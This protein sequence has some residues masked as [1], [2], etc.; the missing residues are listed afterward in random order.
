[1]KRLILVLLLGFMF[2]FT[3]SQN[4]VSADEDVGNIEY[5][6]KTDSQISADI[7]VVIADP[8]GIVNTDTYI[9]VQKNIL[10][11]EVAENRVIYYND[12]YTSSVINQYQPLPTST[13]PTLSVN[14]IKLNQQILAG[15]SG[16][17]SY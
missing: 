8:S 2:S 6:L 14:R 3:Y 7:V 17:L 4:P 15:T 11:K 12:F 13:S 5:T 1:M 10:R 16:G 9:C